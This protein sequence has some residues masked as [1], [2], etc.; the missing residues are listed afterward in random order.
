MATKHRSLSSIAVS[1]LTA[2]AAAIIANPKAYH[3][4]QF[5][6]DFESENEAGCVAFHHSKLTATARALKLRVKKHEEWLR[7]DHFSSTEDRKSV[8]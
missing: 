8:V 5:I 1:T 7:L 2:I 3:Q 6:T 4:N